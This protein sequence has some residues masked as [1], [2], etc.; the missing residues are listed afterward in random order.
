[1]PIFFGWQMYKMTLVLHPIVLAVFYF[2]IAIA[3]LL[4]NA[5][6]MLYIEEIGRTVVLA[7]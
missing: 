5:F 2:I 3:L 4:K 1:M 7:I 6:T